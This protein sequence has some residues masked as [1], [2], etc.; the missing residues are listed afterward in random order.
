MSY[1]LIMKKLIVCLSLVLVTVFSVAFLSAPAFA[2]VCEEGSIIKVNCDTEGGGIW[3]ILEI[4]VNI[5]TV[6]IFVAAVAGFVIAGVMY[7]TAAGDEAKVKKAKE[8]IL[9]IIIGLLVFAVLRTV[10]GFMMPGAGV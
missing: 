10:F 4:V 1:N 2:D 6:G 9:N 7:G 3:E 8:W 5:L